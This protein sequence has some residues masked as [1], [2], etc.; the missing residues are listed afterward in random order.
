MEWLD[1][2]VSSQLVSNLALTLIHFI[3]QGAALGAAMWLALVCVPRNK[4]NLRYRLAVTVLILSVISPIMTFH[5]ISQSP[6]N[7]VTPA[8]LSE[9]VNSF[10]T[11]VGNQSQSQIITGSSSETQTP[12]IETSKTNVDY[13][14]YILIA[15]VLGCLIMTAKFVLDLNR[16]FKLTREGVAKVSHRVENI[17]TSL[18]D[19]YKLKRRITILKSRKVN[20]PVVIGWLRP[21]ILLPIAITIG[22][23]TKH[24]ELIIA[25]EL[26]H[27]KR[28]DFAVNLLQSLV[29]ICLF[30]H[31]V[32]YWINKVIR[33]EREYICDQYALQ[34]LGN[35]ESAKINL[36]KALLGTE[37][38]REGNLSLVAVAASGGMLKHRIS[39]I[40]DSQYKPATS[41]KSITIGFMVFLFS[42]AALSTTFNFED[43]AH[44][45]SQN[46]PIL[47]ETALPVVRQKTNQREDRS[48]AQ[49]P[50]SLIEP[51]TIDEPSSKDKP[52]VARDVV[53]KLASEKLTSVNKKV[54]SKSVNQQGRSSKTAQNGDRERFNKT[55]VRKVSV[56]NKSNQSANKRKAL[57]PA[58]EKAKDKPEIK[59]EV[60]SEERK[61]VAVESAKTAQT[62]RASGVNKEL[63]LDLSSKALSDQYLLPNEAVNK[64]S[65]LLKTASLDLKSVPDFKEPKAIFTPYP[66][67][68]RR[69]WDKMINQTVR[70]N[71]SIES[72]GHVSN[73]N[74]ME[75]ADE[76][77]SDEIYRRLKHWKY[78]PAERDGKRVAHLTSLEFVFKAP[79]KK[80]IPTI[81]T[82]SRIRR[83]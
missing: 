67:Y 42:F 69:A 82:G 6:T 58:L 25:H 70:V 48:E 43:T 20:V 2:L 72:D 61:N 35:D 19:K 26:A 53:E 71:F 57:N 9:S 54:I 46:T 64:E 36:A 12:L 47:A 76:A 59:S 16:T 75:D 13:L 39:H 52:M 45:S 81:M 34:V 49:T 62:E 77:F 31:P 80:P 5:L 56:K 44:A 73:I 30:Y 21:V 1:G 40:L 4:F 24:L 68:P 17:V 11:N 50:Q 74:I 78:Q 18:S 14:S 8:F 7:I 65:R 27:I 15:W 22:L 10:D 28:M 60:E 55:A 37:E 32:I 38:L 51:L 33:D 29:Q 41:L 23:E 83:R 3:W 63:Y 79:Q 66:K